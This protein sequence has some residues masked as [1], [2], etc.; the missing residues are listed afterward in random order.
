[1]LDVA[2]AASLVVNP[3]VAAKAMQADPAADKE[4]CNPLNNN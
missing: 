2:V 1:M 4:V 3:A